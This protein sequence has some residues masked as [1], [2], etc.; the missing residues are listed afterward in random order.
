[1]THPSKMTTEFLAKLDEEFGIMLNKN[2]KFAAMKY[3]NTKTY[4]KRHDEI[5]AELRKRQQA[6]G[7]N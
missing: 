5:K 1:M 4:K 2:P 3:S 7:K 6:R